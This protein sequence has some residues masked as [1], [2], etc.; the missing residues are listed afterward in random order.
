MRGLIVLL[1]LSGLGWAQ[2]IRRPT[3]DVSDTTSTLCT[4][5]AQASSSMASAR[6]ADVST[7]GMLSVS[8]TGLTDHMQ[9]RRLDTFAAAS[10]AYSALALKITSSCD[11]STGLSLHENGSCGLE[12]SLNSGALW[13]TLF[14]SSSG[15]ALATSSVSLSTAQDLSLIRVRTCGVGDM[16]GDGTSPGSASVQ[17]WDI[18][19]EGNLSAGTGSTAAKRRVID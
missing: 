9:G 12:Y 1:I 17:I 7:Y 16:A 2:E 18:R 3:A 5:T 8:G 11:T 19:T 15:W 6:D 14:T 10:G 13:T 4:G